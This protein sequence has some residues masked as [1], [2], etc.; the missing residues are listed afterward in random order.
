MSIKTLIDKINAARS[1]HAGS[2]IERKKE[3]MSK[4]V[5]KPRGDFILY[6]SINRGQV[7]GIAMPD[8]AAEGKDLIIV[9]VGPDVKDLQ[10]GDRVLVIGTPGETVSRVP[11]TNYLLTRQANAVIVIT[12]EEEEEDGHPGNQ[13]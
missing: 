8:Q 2:H 9:A 13:Q 5:Y 3:N 10:P 12:Q 7:R 1:L 4:I 11:G 6:Q